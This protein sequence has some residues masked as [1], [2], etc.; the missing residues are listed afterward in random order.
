MSAQLA[1]EYRVACPH[2]ELPGSGVCGFVAAL[3]VLLVF[4]DARFAGDVAIERAAPPQMVG[5]FTGTY[6][7]GMPVY[8]LPPLEVRAVRTAPQSRNPEMLP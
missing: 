5:K 8:R 6:E 1:I 2:R 4:A 3:L 7:N